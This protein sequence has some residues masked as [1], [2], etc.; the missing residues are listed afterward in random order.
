[1]AEQ[2]AA[3][4]E[5]LLGWWEDQG[6]DPCDA[7]GIA[8]WLWLQA[9]MSGCAIPNRFVAAK[10]DPGNTVI[11]EENHPEGIGKSEGTI[12]DERIRSSE[13][14]L[15]KR[16]PDPFAAT[17]FPEPPSADGE[18]EKPT[19][20]LFAESQLPDDDDVRERL[21]R[22]KGFV[23]LLLRQEPMLSRPLTL[24]AAL[25]PL[26][27]KQ[28]H[29]HWRVL[30]EPRT[31]ERSA[32]LGRPW[33]VL[34]PRMAAAV[35]VEIWLDAGVAMAVWQPLAE[36]FQRV[37]ASSQ[38]FARVSLLQFELKHLD[39]TSYQRAIGQRTSQPTLLTLVLSDTAGRHWWDGSMARWLEQ[40]AERQPLAV[41]HTLPLR[42]RVRTALRRGIA[43][44]LSNRLGLGPNS[45]YQAVAVSTLDPRR[46]LRSSQLPM[47]T[48]LKL[49]VLSLNPRDLAP[50]GA[51]VMGDGL[52]R[53]GG[54]VMSVA[55]RQQ[56]PIS[57]VTSP[58]SS[59][60]PAAEAESLWQT[61]RQ[62]ASPEAP[63]SDIAD[64]RSTSAYVAGAAALDGCG[65][66]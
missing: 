57:P 2:C 49:P 59:D 52:A 53:T 20:G 40:I 54:T 3:N 16:P 26:L 18:K 64:G 45:G 17:P 60:D 63:A 34:R 51:L 58:R 56:I 47:P 35:D 50:W 31:A 37:L 7:R 55:D 23:P 39:P 65:T 11:G 28:P 46:R 43:V 14:G 5:A 42:Y 48:G 36:E 21:R 27:Q 9:S 33:P 19:A 22:R 6:G 62:Q 25:R 24:L 38:A 44:T 13:H 10:L 66:T 41:L 15:D 61:F 29:P 30:D 8:D 1:V 12:S 4:L 32:E